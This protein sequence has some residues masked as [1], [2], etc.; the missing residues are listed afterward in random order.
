MSRKTGNRLFFV[1]IG[2]FFIVL[3][4]TLG[5]WTNVAGAL[6]AFGVLALG[7]WKYGEL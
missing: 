3:P 6:G 2:L 7:Y 5:Q 1:L 4:T